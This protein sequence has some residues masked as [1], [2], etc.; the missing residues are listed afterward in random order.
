MQFFLSVNH[1]GQVSLWD[2]MRKAMDGKQNGEIILI[3]DLTEAQ[4]REIRSAQRRAR[5]AR[6]TS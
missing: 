6:K 3:L 2:T 4:V 1:E 5:P